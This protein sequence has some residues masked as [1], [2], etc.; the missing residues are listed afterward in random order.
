MTATKLIANRFELHNLLGRGG[1]GDVYR[2]TDTQTGETVAVKALNPEVLERDP[3]MLERF[4]REG[5]ALRQLNHPNIVKMLTTFEE[6][7]RYYLVMEYVREGSL[8]DL[9]SVNGPLPHER[10]IQIALDLADALTRAH[11]LGIIHRDLKPANVLLAEDGTP[12]LADFGIAHL[13]NVSSLTQ[14]GIA[15]GSIDYLSPEAC[16]GEAPDERTDIWSFG[17]LLFQ[18]LSGQKPF[19]GDSMVSKLNA[20]LNQKIP[21]L[22]QLAPDAPDALIDLV[23]RMLQKDSQQRIPSIRL[24]G[25]ELEAILKGR[26]PVTLSHPVSIESR[27]ETPTPS[28]QKAKHNLPTQPTLFVGRQAELTELAR[29]LNDPSTRLVTILG[30]GGMGKT[31]LSLEAGKAQLDKYPNGVYFVS[32]APLD[33]TDAIVPATAHVLGFSFYGGGEPRKQLLDYLQEKSMLLIMDNFEHLLSG[34]DLVGE[35]LNTASQVKIIST[36]RARLNMQGEQLFRLGGMD[37]PDWETPADAMEYSAVKLFMQSACRVRSDFELTPENLKFVAR[38]CKLVEGTPLGILLAASWVEMLSPEEIAKEIEKSVDFLE[39]DQRDLPERQQSMRAVFDYS[40]NLLSPNEQEVFKKLSVF[41]GGFTREAAQEVTGAKLRE[42][43]ALVDKSLLH[44]AP[45]GRYEMHEL[46]RQYARDKLLESGESGQIRTRHLDFFLQ[47]A[48]EAEPKLRGSEQHDWLIRL[49]FEHDNLRAALEWSLNNGCVQ[50]GLRLAYALIWFWDIRAYWREGMEVTQKLLMQTEASPR[51]LSRANALLTVVTLSMQLRSRELQ[52]QYLE[53]SIDILREQG[54]VGKWALAM[55]LGLAGVDIFS[56]DLMKARSMVEESMAIARSLGD[57]WLVAFTLAY[58]GHL[59]TT[60]LDHVQA[61]K[62]L[63]ESLELFQSLGDRR[64][65]AIVLVTLAHEDIRQGD[66]AGARLRFQQALPILREERD[67]DT[68]RWALNAL[69]VM[70]HAEGNYDLAKGYYSEALENARDVGSGIFSPAKNLGC[71]LL[72]EGNLAEAKMLFVEC[73]DL[74]RRDGSK[75][76]IAYAIQGYAGLAAV[77][78]QARK[79]IMLLAAT[80]KLQE[81]AADKSI[82]SP[83]GEADFARNLSIAREQL[84]EAT[85]NEAWEKGR[86]LTLEQAIKLASSDAQ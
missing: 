28:L 80:R 8:Q 17:V 81:D 62:L 20:I 54:D 78:K 83:A 67:K 29:L 84:D 10:V 59:S 73:M 65:L 58:A 69:G 49:D 82:I 86:S 19:K 31:R 25:A 22:N 23:Y 24:V 44:R 74:A 85:F 2:A 14:T 18:L 13:S 32:L 26:E 76:T 1:M 72:Y 21:D 52:Q 71:I 57:K 35:I 70:A 12:R 46:L 42:L 39:T 61:Q 34:V 9:L 63:E 60:K 36:S 16:R 64:W 68:L 7:Q 66:F 15:I 30:A 33:S 40:W 50:K 56:D 43:M 41:R 11:R 27:F 48:E 45:T 3:S 51:T 75:A 37:F 53:E 47:L 79:A 6:N 55:G 5:D 77:Q 4:I 38:I